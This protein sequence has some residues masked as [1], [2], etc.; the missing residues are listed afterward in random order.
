MDRTALEILERVRDFA[1]PGPSRAA[2]GIRLRQAGELRLN[3]DRPWQP[4]DARQHIDA[5][6]LEF[7]WAARLR[8]APLVHT[9]VTE[10]FQDGRGRMEAKLLGFQVER[11][12][13]AEVDATELTRLLTELVWCPMALGHPDLVFESV[14]DR[15]V[16][17]G[18]KSGD[19]ALTGVTMRVD[20]AG[21]VLEVKAEGRPRLI[22]NATLATNWS[23]RFDDYREL[24]GVRM[25]VTGELTWALPDGQFTYFR[26]R[27]V[28][29]AVLEAPQSPASRTST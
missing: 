4:F 2:S 26:G 16:R 28:E 3:L 9:T 21:R 20:D 1:V 19:P 8:V 23:G 12:V 5:R 10:A 17:V 7:H 6:K 27:I 18:V 15:T 22:G 29:A 14:D 24:A 25:P 13:G 11:S